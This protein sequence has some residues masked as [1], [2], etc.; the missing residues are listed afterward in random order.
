MPAPCNE[1]HPEAPLAV[2]L[3][4]GYIDQMDRFGPTIVKASQDYRDLCM[5]TMGLV[6]KTA[7]GAV[8]QS[9]HKPPF[10]NT[11]ADVAGGALKAVLKCQCSIVVAAVKVNRS[12]A[13][14]IRDTLRGKAPT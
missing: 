4:D 2:K 9:G 14:L 13:V 5:S 8:E 11:I 3:L 6:R 7:L 1:N 10:I 12:S